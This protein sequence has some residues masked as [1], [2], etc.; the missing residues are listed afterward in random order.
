MISFVRYADLFGIP[1][2]KVTILASVLGRLPV[3]ITGLALL[4]LVQGASQSFARAGAVS[5]CYV[6]GLAC[7]APV[8]GRV[9][10]RWGPRWPL[11]SCAALYPSALIA[12]LVALRSSAPHWAV[13]ALAA[14][15]GAGLPPITVCMRSFF[16]RRLGEDPLLATAYSLE[17]VLIETIFIAGPMFVAVLVALASAALA[18][19]AAAACGGVGALLFARSP[20]LARWRIEPRARP[21]LFGPLAESRLV[22]L[23]GVITC[24]SIAFG[25]IEI[26]VTAFAAEAGRRALA[27]VILGLMSIGSVLGGLTYG[28][29]TWRLPLRRQFAAGLFLMGVGA[30]LLAVA[31]HMLFFIVLSVTAGLVMAPVLAMQSMLVAKLAPAQYA[32]EAFTWS[33][34]ALLAGVGLGIAAGGW[35]LAHAHAPAVL[36]AAGGA[37]VI[38]SA[39]ALLLR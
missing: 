23:L 27:G 9:I 18:V 24:Y 30:L 22:A 16:K 39:L 31:P 7:M 10:D 35:I 1:G 37:S 4:L 34:T 28:S 15:A 26:G 3:G 20:V 12:L 32:T 19:F 6:A 11:L 29:R 38:A 8:V 25:L 17:S 13:L 2:L 33:A 36:F 21:S 14:T 5:A